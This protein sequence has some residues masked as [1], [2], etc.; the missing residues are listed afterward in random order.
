LDEFDQIALGILD[1]GEANPGPLR[2]RGRGDPLGIRRHGGGDG[3][4]QIGH[5]KRPMKVG[6]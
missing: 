2:V 3:L 6:L 5:G 1:V 4:F